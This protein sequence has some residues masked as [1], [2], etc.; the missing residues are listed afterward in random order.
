MSKERRAPRLEHEMMVSITSPQGS[1][2][3]WGTNLS[4]GGVFVNAPASAIAQ[5]QAGA[6]VDV[7]LSLPGQPG[8]KLKGRIAWASAAKGGGADSGMGIEFVAPDD[9]TLA[10]IGELMER[11]RADLTPT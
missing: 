7:L 6:G 10:R 8:C 3:G 5:A 11:L 1:F 9:S 2:S 4:V